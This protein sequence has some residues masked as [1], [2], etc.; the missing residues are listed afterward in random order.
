M[1][2]TK[3]I[4]AALAVLGL[5]IGISWGYYVLFAG[6]FGTVQKG[7]L[8]R[9]AQPDADDIEKYAQKYGI[10]SILNL[11]G[12]SDNDDWYKEEISA[13]KKFNL[14]HY[15]VAISA[16]HEPSKEQMLQIIQILKEA[17]K[18][19]LVH[20]LGGADRTGL[21]TSIYEYA[22]AGQPAK[23]AQQNLSVFHGHLPYF[24][25]KTIAMDRAFDAFV[26]SHPAESSKTE[27]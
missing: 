23:E 7:V 3:K 6:N 14:N 19:I 22:I 24:G 11:Q 15:D 17:P 16:L 10:K 27:R 1:N 2:K 8:Y 25:N 21:V 9:S 18:P 4:L 5:I 26:A 12:K 20:C 13:S